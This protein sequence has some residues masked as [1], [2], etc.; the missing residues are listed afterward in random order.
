MTK[1]T[2]YD[3]CS[4]CPRNCGADRSSGEIGYCRMGSTPRV[5]RISL[6]RWEEPIISGESG[7]GTVFF[8]GCSLGCIYCQNRVISR[9][10]GGR[11]MTET[12]LAEA[13]L[14]LEADGA[15]NINLVTP[16]HFA[17]SIIEAVK[18]ARSDGLGLPVVY[19][20]SSYDA[21]AT[22][23]SLEGTVDVYLPDLKYYRP[24]TAEK[25]SKAK[26]YPTVAREA[27]AEMVRQKPTPVIKDG[28]ISSGVVVRL[29]LLPGHLAECK[30]NLK[31][32][33]D[34]YGD[35]IYISLMSQ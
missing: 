11:E 15:H 16:T 19:N 8:V 5:A 30:L 20:T 10:E 9:G 27:I 22:L 14:G 13:F 1:K 35:G 24:K 4:L 12:E 32:L 3:A 31:Y 7:S 26:D 23:K 34:T 6:H 25:L 17:P 2:E 18:K 33:Y 28:L 29:L 21:V